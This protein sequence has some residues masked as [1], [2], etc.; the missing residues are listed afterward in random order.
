[1]LFTS[2]YFTKSNVVSKALQIEASSKGAH[3]AVTKNPE[4]LGLG[5]DQGNGQSRG[6]PSDM[7]YLQKWVC[8]ELR[9]GRRR[10]E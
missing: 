2:A 7:S 5:S 8:V 1:M 4:P 6:T 3:L 9:H 10:A